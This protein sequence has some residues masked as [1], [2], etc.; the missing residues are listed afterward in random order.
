MRCRCFC[1]K[2]VHLDVQVEATVRLSHFLFF[3]QRP[4]VVLDEL[5]RNWRLVPTSVFYDCWSIAMKMHFA[6]LT[7]F[8]AAVAISN[9]VQAQQPSF[10]CNQATSPTEHAICA[11]QD[12]SQKDRAISDLY[13][14]LRRVL[15]P[16]AR[17]RLVAEQRAWLDRRNACGADTICIGATSDHRIR[18]LEAWSREVF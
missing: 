18:E 15:A 11:S 17:D 14:D 10:D 9:T 4:K 3:V 12:L 5:V 7:I 1:G 8:G 2:R 13:S 16:T 6:T